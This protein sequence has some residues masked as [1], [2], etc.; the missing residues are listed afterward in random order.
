MATAI[1]ETSR[2]DTWR[3]ESFLDSLILELDKAQ[4]TLSVKGVTRRLT[5]TV[6]D[7]DLDLYVFP[8]YADGR[9]RFSVARPG[10]NGASRISF[11]L[12][13]ITDRQI[14]ETGKA[15]TVA[16]DMPIDAVED[17]DQDVKDSLKS[18]GVTSASDLERMGE[19]QID[20]G[21]IVADKTDGRKSVSYDKLAS[22]I[23][24]ARRRRLAPTMKSLRARRSEDG[25]VLSLSGTRLASESPEAGF[26]LALVNDRPV[27][28]LEAG[29]S[30][31]KLGVKVDAM[32]QGKNL[33][34]IALDPHAVVTLE[35][36]GG[37]V[38]DRGGRP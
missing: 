32:Q 23:G 2:A 28:I 35:I 1:G 37:A 12:G 17:L 29:P 10:E 7:F 15:P 33:V 30:L 34:R 11:Q 36:D 26:P 38:D 31:I 20:L 13:S 19:R 3:L 14:R 8:S 21:Q 6:K 9:L 24:K 25:Y 4:D 22:I 18:V 5:Y 27:E 16:G